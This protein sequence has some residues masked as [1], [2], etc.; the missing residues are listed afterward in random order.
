MVTLPTFMA[1]HSEILDPKVPVSTYILMQWNDQTMGTGTSHMKSFMALCLSI[2]LLCAV[3][4]LQDSDRSR[5]VPGYQTCLI[6]FVT[7][8][9]L[10]LVCAKLKNC[11]YGFS[12]ESMRRN[13]DVTLGAHGVTTPPSFN[14]IGN[15]IK[16]RINLANYPSSPSEY[17][18]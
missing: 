2:L 6:L 7:H 1:W 8:V 10:L 3:T 16:I 14:I 12:Q 17:I 5:P 9:T 4:L 13:S 18:H 11:A 15:G